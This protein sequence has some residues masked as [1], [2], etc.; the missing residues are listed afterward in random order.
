MLLQR[1][2]K[3]G[4]ADFLSN[5]MEENKHNSK[6]LG[7]NAKSKSS[8]QNFVLNIN[9]ENC[10]DSKKIA[11]HF[12]NFFTHV[13]SNLVNKLPPCPNIFNSHSDNF[14]HFYHERNPNSNKFV[15]H[16]VNEDFVFKEL[17]HLNPFKSTGLDN[18]L[19]NF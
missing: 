11:N 19:L 9:N 7:S 12:N 16:T 17:S 8:S 1:H 10:F 2:V 13:A 5:K 14:K 18:I 15:L 6:K 4:K 3:Q